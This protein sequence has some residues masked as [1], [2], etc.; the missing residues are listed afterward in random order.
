M[1]SGIEGLQE[2]EQRY[3]YLTSLPEKRISAAL[4]EHDHNRVIPINTQGMFDGTL[5]HV[6]FELAEK[7]LL[8]QL[9]RQPRQLFLS[10]LESLKCLADMT[11]NRRT[12]HP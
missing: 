12:I 7:V 3:D 11:N 1:C 8:W 4:K 2:S 9:V 5:Q 6:I 10:Q